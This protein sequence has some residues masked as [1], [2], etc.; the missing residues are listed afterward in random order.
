MTKVRCIGP[1]TIC[2]QFEAFARERSEPTLLK[3]EVGNR[4]ASL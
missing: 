3:Q 1:G 4:E 2:A